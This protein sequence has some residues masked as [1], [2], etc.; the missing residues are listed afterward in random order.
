MV[1]SRIRVVGGSNLLCGDVDAYNQWKVGKW[2]SLFIRGAVLLGVGWWQYQSQVTDSSRAF[3][4]RTLC[5]HRMH[6]VRDN[7]TA[8]MMGECG[9]FAVANTA[10]PTMW[11][12]AGEF[13][14]IETRRAEVVLTTL[15]DYAPSPVEDLALLE[16]LKK[17]YRRVFLWPQGSEDEKYLKSLGV[18]VDILDHS[19]A[20]L[21]NF[22]RD[23][24]DAHYIGT[25]LHCGIHCLCKGLKSLIMQVDNRAAEIS[26]DTGLLTCRRG[27][28]DAVNRWITRAAYPELR[29]PLENISSCKSTLVASLAGRPSM[30]ASRTGRS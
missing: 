25:R 29:L 13:P 12:L 9:D 8:V 6:S 14:R 24:G 18:S 2:S 7:Y 10:C 23:H 28:L 15:T 27:D 4:R 21:E 11:P 26:K 30:N 17:R 5:R 1:S 20:A 19:L 3:Y 16:L 22:L